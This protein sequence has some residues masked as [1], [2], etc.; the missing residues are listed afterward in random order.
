MAAG[1]SKPVGFQ[2]LLMNLTCKNM[3]WLILFAA[4][5][6]EVL[7]ALCLGKLRTAEGAALA[8][9]FTGFAVSLVLSIALL[10]RASS[11]IPLGTAYAVWTGLGAT[12]IVLVGIL[13]F[14]EPATGWR[15]LFLFT[16][17]ASIVGLK[18]VSPV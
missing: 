11:A 2:L 18:Y 10:Y 4:G 6:F 14:R 9:W 7:F 8:A 3:H 1:D 5:I 15:L 12:G 13:V 16:L 17:I